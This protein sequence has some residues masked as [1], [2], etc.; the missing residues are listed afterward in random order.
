MTVARQQAVMSMVDKV[1][2]AVNLPA[3][4]AN[5]MPLD[6]ML[7][8]LRWALAENDR[9]GALAAA[10]AAAP[11]LHPKLSATELH[12]SGSLDSRPTEEILIE[13]TALRLK[14]EAAASDETMATADA[15]RGGAP[16]SLRDAA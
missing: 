5:I 3:E 6:A 9:P 11:Y 12:V 10:A 1:T 7:V 15:Q 16:G 8:C 2:A 13:L 4:I 14:E